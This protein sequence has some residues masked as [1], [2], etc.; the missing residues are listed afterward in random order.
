MFKRF[1][2]RLISSFTLLAF[3]VTSGS[4]SY[5]QGIV[6]MPA[7]GTMVQVSSSYAPA[8]LK[9]IKVY[10]AEPL[11]LNFLIDTGNSGL[12]DSSLELESSKLIRYFLASLTVP[13]NDLWVNLSPYES[14]RIIPESFGLT[15]MGRDLL[16]ED[17]IL[18]QLA[19]SMMYPEKAL[20]SQVWGRIYALAVE[21]YGTTD[22]PLDTFNKVWIIPDEATVYVNGNTAFIVKS[23]LKAM[24]DT[25]YLALMNTDK[26]QQAPAATAEARGIA[27]KVIRE[28][29]LPVIENEINSGENF[30]TLRQIYHAMILSTWFKRNLK[31]SLIGQV[32][33]E[34]N[35]VTGIDLASK[36]VKEKIWKQYVEAFKK[37][38]FNYIKEETDETTQEV[39]PRKYFSGGFNYAQSAITIEKVDATVMDDSAQKGKTG[40]LKDLAVNLLPVSKRPLDLNRRKF[41]ANI[42]KALGLAIVGPELSGLS[43]IEPVAVRLNKADP[44]I[45]LML[46]SIGSASELRTDSNGSWVISAGSVPFRDIIAAALPEEYKSKA[47]DIVHVFKNAALQR[48]NVLSQRKIISAADLDMIITKVWTEMTSLSNEIYRQVKARTINLN[49]V[50]EAIDRMQKG[51]P[52]YIETAKTPVINRSTSDSYIEEWD[53]EINRWENEGGKVQPINILIRDSQDKQGEPL[54]VADV[55]PNPPAKSGINPGKE[56]NERKG[57]IDLNPRNFNLEETGGQVNF[58]STIAPA[59]LADRIDG[60]TPIILSVTSVNSSQAFFGVVSK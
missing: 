1:V 17:Y 3:M 18:K 24:L 45:M 37:G 4:S 41:L 40:E 22:I 59:H 52:K 9:G 30:S 16:S 23:H 38:V 49:A 8:I 39:I 20:G 11:R 60:F 35:K 54:V 25:D 50:E 12:Q 5:A 57:G 28:V 51:E 43:I 47:D 19:S 7:P 27:Q 31:R 34:Q 44:M 21:K 13:E 36:E 10:P 15:E 48:V 14:D 26:K 33:S 6:F 46:E 55:R 2:N 42:S 29:I 53:N 58:N 32:Y 56:D